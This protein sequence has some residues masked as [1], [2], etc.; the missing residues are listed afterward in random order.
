MC[1]VVKCPSVEG[2]KGPRAH[3]SKGLRVHKSKVQ[4][5]KGPSA[6]AKPHIICGIAAV[7]FKS[8]RAY[9][10]KKPIL[11]TKK[12]PRQRPRL[13]QQRLSVMLMRAKR[14]TVLA[15]GRDSGDSRSAKHA[16]A[17]Y[18]I[19]TTIAD[20]VHACRHSFQPPLPTSF[21][22]QHHLFK[23][24]CQGRL[25]HKRLVG[26]CSCCRQR[27]TRRGEIISKTERPRRRVRF[28]KI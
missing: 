5:S 23:F 1:K 28:M 13:K 6:Q 19:P 22:R 2:S 27:P 20:F 16:D 15:N 7:F 9:A 4:G 26:R 14:T 8:I 18:S 11:Q 21:M 12:R 17:A 3:K 25:L 10:S 24:C